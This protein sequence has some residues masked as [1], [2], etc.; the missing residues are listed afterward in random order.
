[1][2]IN[3]YGICIQTSYEDKKEQKNL[4][5]ELISLNIIYHSV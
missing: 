5:Y 3:V 1:M 4:L 2:S